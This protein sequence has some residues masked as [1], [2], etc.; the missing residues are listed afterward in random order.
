LYVTDPSSVDPTGLPL[1]DHNKKEQLEGTGEEAQQDCEGTGGEV[2]C[3]CESDFETRVNNTRQK[4]RGPGLH[5]DSTCAYAVT[6]ACAFSVIPGAR[7]TCKYEY[8][9]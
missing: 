8:G 2:H 5:A 4:K 3:P 6:P 9:C 1:V 7:N